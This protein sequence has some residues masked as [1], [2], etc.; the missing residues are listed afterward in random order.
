[1]V[2]LEVSEVELG[3]LEAGAVVVAAAPA[4]PSIHTRDI[5]SV[6]Y[7]IYDASDIQWCSA[8]GQIIPFAIQWR[9]DGSLPSGTTA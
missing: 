5:A 8:E 4:D 3:V 1:M 7:S 6:V 2:E 9:W